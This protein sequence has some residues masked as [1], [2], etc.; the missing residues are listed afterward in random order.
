[1]TILPSTPFPSLPR[2]GDRVR[3]QREGLGFTREQLAHKIGCAAV[4]LYK[5]ETHERRPSLQLAQLLAQHLNIPAEEVI[6]FVHAARGIHNPPRSSL[7]AA[8]TT[9]IG[10]EDALQQISAQLKDEA[11]RLLTLTGSP[12]VGKTQLA[13]AAARALHTAFVDGAY[14]VSLSALSTPEQ[15]RSAIAQT[16]GIGEANGDQSLWH[17]TLQALRHKNLLLL[18]DNFEQVL[19]AAPSVAELLQTCP[20]VKVLIT[21]QAALRLTG[22]HVWPVAPLA[23]APAVHL[24]VAR[25]QAIKPTFRLNPSNTALVTEIC[26]RL[27]GLPLAIELA[28]TRI[29]LFTPAA[30]LAQLSQRFAVLGDGAADAPSR[31]QTLW[32]AIDWS[33]GLLQPDAQRAWRCAAIFAGSF[34]LESFQDI[35]ELDAQRA[36]DLVT[37]LV[38]HSLLAPLDS[39]SPRFML[40]ESLR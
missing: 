5:I 1:M 30:L 15:V 21:S 29:S 23:V 34:S 9:L 4:T 33:Y 13:L 10:R 28:A 20:H 38:H 32:N 3:K 2:F 35:A 39:D 24:F 6:E 19:T 17:K 14:F 27:D 8:L 36:L 40:L 12:G 37:T 25:A 11:A 16:L 22:E 18:L 26:Q 7:P 31:H